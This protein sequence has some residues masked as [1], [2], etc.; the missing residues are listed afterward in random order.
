[1]ANIFFF[2]FFSEVTEPKTGFPFKLQ[3]LN[4]LSQSCEQIGN[5]L[6]AITKS[7]AVK[8]NSPSGWDASYEIL[9]IKCG[10]GGGKA[11]TNFCPFQM[12]YSHLEI[13]CC[14]N[15]L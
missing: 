9:D 5:G 6:F 1:M 12:F 3:K 10:S 7:N 14:L 2:S 4:P 8:K 11:I 13:F 15:P